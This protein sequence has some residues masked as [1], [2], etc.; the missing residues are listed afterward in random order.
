MLRN[1]TNHMIL[2]I[3]MTCPYNVRMFKD[4]N[5]NNNYTVINLYS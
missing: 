5:D 3:H 2:I 4:N 1:S